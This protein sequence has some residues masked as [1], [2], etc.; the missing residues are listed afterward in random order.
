MKLINLTRFHTLLLAGLNATVAMMRFTRY[1]CNR[2]H[3][4]LLAVS[5]QQ[6]YRY[7]FSWTGVDVSIPFC[8]AG[9]NATPGYGRDWK[10]HSGFHTFCSGS[11]CNSCR[12]NKE[13]FPGSFHTL[14]LAGL[15]ATPFDFLF[16][17]IR[18]PAVSIPFARGSQCNCSTFLDK[19][20]SIGSCVPQFQLKL[21]VSSASPGV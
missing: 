10:T 16:D 2:F 13:S 12:G 1:N 8:L 6:V 7:K 4:L 9:L 11:Q 3:T 14:L 15:N 20:L 19:I 17:R 5:M 21:R 18:P